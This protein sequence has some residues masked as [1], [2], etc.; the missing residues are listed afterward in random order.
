M[1]ALVGGKCVS[2]KIL[3]Q[4]KESNKRVGIGGQ[5]PTLRDVKSKPRTRLVF[6]SS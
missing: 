6:H 4:I 5:P 3:K 2:I 1:Y